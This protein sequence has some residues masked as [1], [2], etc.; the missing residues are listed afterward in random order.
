MTDK[1]QEILNDASESVMQ[2]EYE[3]T[4]LRN[5]IEF[6]VAHKFKEEERIARLE[7]SAKEMVTY[8][9]RQTIKQLQDT[10]NAWNS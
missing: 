5:R 6:S 3:V 7:L 9:Y 10:L 1:I 2:A 8:R 4:I